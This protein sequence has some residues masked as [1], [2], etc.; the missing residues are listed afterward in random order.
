MKLIDWKNN[1]KVQKSSF[2][3][4][5]WGRFPKY[6]DFP[7]T[8]EFPKNENLAKK[9][10]FT[11]KEFKNKQSEYCPKIL[12]QISQTIIFWFRPQKMLKIHNKNVFPKITPY[13]QKCVKNSIKHRTTYFSVT[14]V[15]DIIYRRELQILKCLIKMTNNL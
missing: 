7:K 10:H 11:P 15:T 9:Y 1:L 8:W 13:Y 6:K 2:F 14:N 4:K 5:K 3:P 12:S